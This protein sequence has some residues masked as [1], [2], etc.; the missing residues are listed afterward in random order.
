MYSKEELQDG[1]NTFIFGKKIFTYESIDSTNTCAKTLAST[2]I[3][4]GTVVVAEYQT[5]GRGRLGRTWQAEP[6]NNLLF[7]IIIR[8]KLEINKIGLLPFFA[9]VGVAQA[10]EII[11]GKRFECKWP[12]DILLNGKKCCGILMESSFQNNMLEYAIIGIGINVNQ[13][14]FGEDIK[15]RATSLNR[16]CGKEFDRRDVFRQIITSLEL[17]YSEVRIGNFDKTL[18]EWK[19][20]TTM[21]GKQ[22]TLNQAGEHLR[23][24]AIDL[25][26]DGGLILETSNGQR[27]CYAGD[28]IFTKES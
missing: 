9:A 11:T 10:L 18:K 7:S 20:R 16:E 26:D 5:A 21:F 4:E 25:S 1:L 23:G 14:I 28:V 19:S 2:G 6:G 24:R 15:D 27:V 12:N 22:V 3:E 17:L 8:P 13:R